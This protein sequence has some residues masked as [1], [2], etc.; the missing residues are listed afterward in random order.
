MSSIKKKRGRPS[1]KRPAFSC[2]CKQAQ[3]KQ[4]GE[5]SGCCECSKKKKRKVNANPSKG[6][7]TTSQESGNRNTSS[8][9][10]SMSQNSKGIAAAVRTSQQSS[11]RHLEIYK[12]H[13]PHAVR[14]VTDV[15]LH[16][17]ID[18]VNPK[19]LQR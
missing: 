10:S 4:C 7:R 3:C 16:G 2:K 18:Q 17:L 14:L 15:R 5:C 11:Q 12:K 9:S 13:A 8:R 6:R 19:H 1:N